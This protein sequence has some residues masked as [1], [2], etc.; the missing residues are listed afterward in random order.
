MKPPIEDLDLIPAK[1]AA[2]YLGVTTKTLASWR[3]S[4]VLDL[5]YVKIGARVFYRADHIGQFI[6]ANTRTHTGAAS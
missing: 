4:G 2:N 3:C 6:D 5:K 1:K